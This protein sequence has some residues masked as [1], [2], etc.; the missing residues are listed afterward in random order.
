MVGDTWFSDDWPGGRVA[1]RST[2]RVWV[3][4]AGRR[5][6][7]AVAATMQAYPL[8]PSTW[9]LSEPTLGHRVAKVWG[10]SVASRT[11]CVFGRIFITNGMAPQG[12]K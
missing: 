5:S 8:L 6:C 9:P 1:P 7:A 4:L 10:N 11:H 3:S 12:V 2:S